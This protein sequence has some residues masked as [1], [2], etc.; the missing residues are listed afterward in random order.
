MDPTF[1]V[2][3]N[4]DRVWNPRSLGTSVG[5]NSDSFVI[6]SLS[7]HNG[8]VRVLLLSGIWSVSTSLLG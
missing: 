7:V 3:A 8:P 1:L 4:L 6:I 2:A 5:D